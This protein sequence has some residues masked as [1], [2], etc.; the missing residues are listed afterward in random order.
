MP[1]SAV[2]AAE[3]TL[4]IVVRCTHLLSGLAMCDTSPLARSLPR[5]RRSAAAP[6]QCPC[7]RC[8]ACSVTDFA[9][10]RGQA[11][12]QC[13]LMPPARPHPYAHRRQTPSPTLDPAD[14]NTSVLRPHTPT[15]LPHPLWSFPCKHAAPLCHPFCPPAVT[16]ASLT[17]A[18]PFSDNHHK[19]LPRALTA[20]A[21]LRL[22]GSAP[23]V[24]PVLVLSCYTWNPGAA[25]RCV[26]R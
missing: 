23:R 20:L 26:G 21:D 13:T 16:Q 11:L 18:V 9:R 4:H 2:W 25:T 3:D 5:S 15:Q 19:D 14:P 24:C 7:E 1:R 22:R 12:H 17:P 8:Y 6:P 10:Q